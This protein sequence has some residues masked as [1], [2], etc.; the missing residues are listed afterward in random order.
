MQ[1]Q[2]ATT[3]QPNDQHG[4][5]FYIYILRSERDE[6]RF[7]TGLTDDLRKRIRSHNT[8]PSSLHGKMAPMAIESLHRIF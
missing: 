4:K 5:V 6:D 8:G 1:T 7:Y 2:R 3:R